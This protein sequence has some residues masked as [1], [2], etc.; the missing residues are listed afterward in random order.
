MNFRTRGYFGAPSRNQ[1]IHQG[2]ELFAD[3]GQ[4]FLF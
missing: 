3:G 4:A 2:I 1:E